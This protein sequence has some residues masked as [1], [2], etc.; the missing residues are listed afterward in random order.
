[1]A[2]IAEASAKRKAAIEAAL[3]KQLRRREHKTLSELAAELRG[4]GHDIGV[5]HLTR[6]IAALVD[7]GEAEKHDGRP[8]KYGAA[9]K[10]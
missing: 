8:P 5:K 3:R 1:M 9:P 6:P 4:L 7:R 2:T 10:K